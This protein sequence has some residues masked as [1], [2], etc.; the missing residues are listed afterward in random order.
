MGGAKR[1]LYNTLYCGNP[2]LLISPVKHN[3]PPAAAELTGDKGALICLSFRWYSLAY[4]CADGEQMCNVRFL[5]RP[6]LLFR[7][8][9]WHLLHPVRRI[10]VV[11]QMQRTSNESMHTP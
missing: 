7:L 2:T 3:V 5:Q 6:S 4:C 1:D 10:V 8:W 11:L 9:R